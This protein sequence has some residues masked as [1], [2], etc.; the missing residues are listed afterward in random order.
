MDKTCYNCMFNL[1]CDFCEKKEI[2]EC[3]ICMKEV[4]KLVE[5]CDKKYCKRCITYFNYQV[6]TDKKCPKCYDKDC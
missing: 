1:K 2:D 5:C 4:T 3:F 6:K